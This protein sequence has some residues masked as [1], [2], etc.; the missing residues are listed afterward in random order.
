MSKKIMLAIFLISFIITDC[1]NASQDKSSFFIDDNKNII[2]GVSI[3]E[4]GNPYYKSLV[5]GMKL[6]AANKGA[7]LIINDPDTNVDRQIEAVQDFIDKKV[8]A[9]I[10]AAL[11]KEK[12][13]PILGEAMKA[14]IKVVAQSTKVDNCDIFVSAEEWEMGHTI[15]QCA[16]EWIMDKLEGKAQYAILS[17]DGI[18]QLRNREKGIKDGIDEY[19]PESELVDTLYVATTPDEAYEATL[20]LLKKYP[21]LK[22]I[23][24]INDS[25]AIGALQAYEET[26]K[27]SDDVFIGGVDATPEAVELI[28]GG[29]ALRC[30]VDIIPEYNGT[31]DVNFAL[32]L[33]NGQI[34]PNRFRIDTEVVTNN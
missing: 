11:D 16:G 27:D 6:E 21:D 18:L 15:G 29:T 17:Y 10:I 19:A 14:G 9:I 31:I 28:K 13:D 24:S 20:E 34:V 26:E 33:I 22:V 1:S 23:I 7:E 30:T 32:K 12:L 3:L 8:D 5:N 25:G 4:L 2:I